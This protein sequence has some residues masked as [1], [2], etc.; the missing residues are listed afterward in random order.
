MSPRALGAI[1]ALLS[2]RFELTEVFSVFTAVD[3]ASRPVAAAQQWIGD[4]LQRDAPAFDVEG[5][6][7]KLVA[8]AVGLARE[9]VATEGKNA[10]ETWY[11]AAVDRAVDLLRARHAGVDATPIA[12]VQNAVR[13]LVDRAQATRLEAAVR[14][15]VEAWAGFAFGEGTR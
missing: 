3:A 10:L 9:V 1:F 6:T 13:T 15:L 12:P 5:T 8:F 2:T 11:Y 14:A 4:A 7:D